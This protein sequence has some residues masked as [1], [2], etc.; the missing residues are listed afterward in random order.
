MTQTDPN[1]AA[2]PP[3]TGLGTLTHLDTPL[4]RFPAAAAD[5]VIRVRNVRYATAG[6]FEAPAPAGIVP[7]E[8]S[9]LQ[10]TRIACPQPTSPSDELL[11]RP[12]RGTVPDEDCLRLSITRPDGPIDE[13]LPVMVWVH[14]GSYVS[15]AGDL[16]GHDA[17]ALV[18]EQAVVVVTVTSR[19]GQLGYPTDDAAPAN[20]GL[21][22]L[23]AAFRWV[24]AHIAAFGG[25]P[26]RTTAW[27]QS[28]GADAIAHLIAADGS[29]GL[30][31][32]V[33]LQS[34]P[35]GIR[36]GRAEMQ[37]RMRAAAGTL[38]RT[39]PIEELFAAQARAKAAAA[40]SGLRSAMPFGPR[41]GRAPLPA[42]DRI[43][44]V[45]RERAPGLDV[46]VSWNRD[47]TAFFF[48]VDPKLAAL[49]ARPVVGPL[50]RR[51]L[52]RR[53]TDAVYRTAA[54]RFARLLAEAGARVQT[55]EFGGHPNDGR[56]G[57]A[58]AMEVPLLFPSAEAWGDMP[59]LAPAG[60]RTL[61]AAGAAL[62]AAWAEFARDGRVSAAEV[63]TG[64]GWTGSLRL[65]SAR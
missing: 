17:A 40:G 58:H 7:D 56:L 60:G 37:D 65:R 29:D 24:R 25:D 23:I 52:T 33:I 20:L 2:P 32:R 62:R 28:S 5:G 53:T 42:E 22:D 27:G 31:H 39:G 8:A 38:D 47:E 16:I 10:F 41:Y 14:G 50:L 36:T 49:V 3:A 6:R 46:L 63:P 59:L 35:L 61:V 13:P 55:A 44:D 57:S 21:L 51:V 45:W 48:E 18:R 1:R 26:A 34:P 9:A 54:R 19:L 30:F 11:G 4:G 43:E 12:V 15:G 64:D